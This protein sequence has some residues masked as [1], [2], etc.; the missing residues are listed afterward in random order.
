MKKHEAK[1]FRLPGSCRI[2][3]GATLGTLLAGA[4]GGTV[5]K[6]PS[7]GSESH[8]LAYC[9]QGCGPGLDCIGGICTRPCLTGQ[10]SCTDL[11]ANAACTNQSVEPGKWRFAM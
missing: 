1:P 9:E 2:A 8:F 11:A 5:N 3:L 4:C 7:I 6:T 10:A